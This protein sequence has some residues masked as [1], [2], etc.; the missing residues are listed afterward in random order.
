MKILIAEDE[1][2]SAR[3]LADMTRK[4]LGNQI[5]TLHIEKNFDSASLYLK[6]NEIDLLLLDLTLA[7]ENGFEL[8]LN[9]SKTKF[10]TIVVSS[11]TEKAIEAFR[12]EVLDFV[13][14]PFDEERL[15]IALSRFTK[16]INSERGYTQLSITEDGKR[17]LLSHIEIIWA[18]AKGKFSL[19]HTQNKTK[20]QYRK[21][22]GELHSELGK[23]F[24]RVHKS[25][26]IR[27]TKIQEIE[28]GRGGKYFVILP[29]GEKIPLSRT[30][31]KELITT[32]ERK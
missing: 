27:D 13:P 23:N 15:S 1:P 8:L 12:Y 5:E 4:I 24:I 2:V 17:I 19:I 14:K 10:S 25:H 18:T 7:E 20:L 6:T 29:T 21:T 11:Y 30:V 9:I 31:Y 3:R 16:K 28:I 32:R 26:I 22:L